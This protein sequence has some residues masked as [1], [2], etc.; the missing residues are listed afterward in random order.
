[1]LQDSDL[2][3]LLSTHQVVIEKETKKYFF[4]TPDTIILLIK[5]V[6]Q[7]C[8]SQHTLIK[9]MQIIKLS[10]F[11]FQSQSQGSFQVLQMFYKYLGQVGY[12]RGFKCPV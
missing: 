10:N 8:A 7:L 6:T 11:I 9:K 1:M 12:E 5:V 3:N 4:R 2:I